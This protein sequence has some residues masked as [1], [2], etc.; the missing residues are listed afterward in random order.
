MDVVNIFKINMLYLVLALGRPGWRK[1]RTMRC[2]RNSRLLALAGIA[3]F[4]TVMLPP[5]AHGQSGKQ[6]VIVSTSAVNGETISCGCKK[7]DI[8]GIARRATVIKSERAKAA[9]FLLVDA[10]DFGSHAAFEPWMRT[11]FQWE[12]MGKV[13]YDAV[14][15]GP[16]EMTEGLGA[17]LDLCGRVP[18]PQVV[19]ANITDK[20]GT[21]IWPEYLLIEHGGVVF[22]VTGVTDK[23]YYSFNLTRG[24]QKKDD[25]G[26]L[27]PRES[28]ISVVPTL[29]EKADIVVVLLHTGSGD[30]RRMLDGIEGVDVVVVGHSPSYKFIPE[31]IGQTLLI[32][33]GNRG[34]YVNVLELTL[35]DQ[36]TIVDYNGE[37]RPL[38]DTVALD[39]DFDAVVTKFNKKYDG[40]MPQDVKTEA[41]AEGQ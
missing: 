11:Q 40:L 27:S 13:G 20:S 18:Q 9:A 39:E 38:G 28:L 41:K 19:S 32:Q 25:F 3:A 2:H 24:K 33:A 7:K 10:G 36:N 21:R 15:P 30:A 26:F 16:N 23:S 37:A 35:N 5:T 14:T 8:G 17:L 34:Q 6:A 22:G 4:L 1:K 29:R 12:M 31:R